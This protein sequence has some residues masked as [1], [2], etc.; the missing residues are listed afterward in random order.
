MS[1]TAGALVWNSC[2]SLEKMSG[3]KERTKYLS[4]SETLDAKTETYGARRQK[5]FTAM[6]R[7][8][9]SDGVISVIF[10]INILFNRA[11][12]QW[13]SSL[14]CR[15][16]NVKHHHGLQHGK[17]FTTCCVCYILSNQKMTT[18]RIFAEEISLWW[19]SDPQSSQL[20]WP[21]GGV[22]WWGG[23]SE[24]GVPRGE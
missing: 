22:R 24:A 9:Q 16:V 15:G 20:K 11:D 3:G 13:D 7:K 1:G 19:L 2:A 21:R 8:G 17:L 23:G 12:P 14:F 18:T 5:E 4:T 6:R 10:C